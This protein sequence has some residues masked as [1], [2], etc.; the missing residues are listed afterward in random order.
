M[1][2]LRRILCPTDFSDFSRRA[3]EHA[4]A[5]ARWYEAEVAV[6]YV[7]PLMAPPPPEMPYL[8][9]PE[10]LTRE[11]KVRAKAD[12]RA[13]VQ[14][15]RDTGVPVEVELVEGEPAAEIVNA[16]TRDGVDLV[17]MGTHGRSGFE[18]LVLGS[19]TERVLR[20][21]P[22]PVLTVSRPAVDTAPAGAFRRILC[23]V[24]LLETSEATAR[25]AFSLAEEAGAEVLLLHVLEGRAHPHTRGA[26]GTELA[27][28]RAELQGFAHQDLHKL[29]PEGAR[30]WCRPGELVSWG[31]AERE[32]LAVAAAREA[33]LI[34]MGAHGSAF[35]QVVFGSTAQ[36]VVRGA[37]CPVLTVRPH[38]PA[39]PQGEPALAGRASRS[40]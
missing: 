40:E 4:A 29:V 3:L 2:E 12:L 39:A 31:R 37:G 6:V 19:V 22:C 30:A 9:G 17:V 26:F 5:A 10:P 24:D 7:H 34:V 35:E 27:E 32:I 18:R 13:F 1:I 33:D 8:P 21:A 28:Y 15:V 25:Y 14:P 20:K 23:P 11:Q 36:H 16:A 38:T